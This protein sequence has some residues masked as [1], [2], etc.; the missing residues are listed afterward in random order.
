MS[1]EAISFIK[2]LLTRD[3]SRRMGVNEAGFKRLKDHAWVSGMCW[4]ILHSKTVG[5][6]FIPDVSLSYPPRR[7]LCLMPLLFL[8]K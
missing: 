8:G 2:E 1:Q 4:D 7:K 3:V 6:P 5:A